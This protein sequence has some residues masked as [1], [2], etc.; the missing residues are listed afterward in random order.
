MMSGFTESKT[1]LNLIIYP[2]HT[3]L[4]TDGADIPSNLIESN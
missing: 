1:V 3:T 2:D 4:K